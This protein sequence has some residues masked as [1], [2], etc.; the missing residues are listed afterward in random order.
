MILVEGHQWNTRSRY[1]SVL[2]LEGPTKTLGKSF[3]LSVSF[4]LGALVGQ[5]A[6]CLLEVC[7]LFVPAHTHPGTREHFLVLPKVELLTDNRTTSFST[8]PDRQAS[9]RLSSAM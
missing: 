1:P 3:Q 8:P 6:T 7:P 9:P 2:A 4:C 5:S